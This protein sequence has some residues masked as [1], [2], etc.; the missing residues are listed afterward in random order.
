MRKTKID[1][2]PEHAAPFV[3]NKGN[4]FKSNKRPEGVN[5]NPLSVNTSKMAKCNITVDCF[6]FSNAIKENAEHSY[7]YN[8]G[9]TK[10]VRLN[11]TLSGR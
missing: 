7:E 2:H 8:L 1:T 9:K 3:F 4:G 5:C 10:L 6:H 11:S